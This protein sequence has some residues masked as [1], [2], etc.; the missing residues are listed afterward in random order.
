MVGALILMLPISHNG[1]LSFLDAFFTS[2]SAVCVT[3]LIVKDTATEFTFF[4]QLIII[5]LV[6]IGGVGYLAFATFAI[7]VFG[8]QITHRDY[9]ML[10]AS[11]SYNS[12]KGVLIFL[13]QTV[14]FI[15]I[16]EISCALILTISFSSKM[17]ITDAIWAGIFH[18]IAAFNNAGFSTFQT[19][20]IDYRL[21]MLVVFIVTF[22]V[23][24]GG[25]GY[26]TIF[27]VYN[28]KKNK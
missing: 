13:K 23:I 15:L 20:L 11:A 19:S 25:I 3:G 16:L 1:E 18:S 2:T 28:Y 7:I 4:G 9:A 6:Q 21:D 22:L 8:K 26:I 14:G 27:D 12:A 24:F 5:I 10:K 17:P